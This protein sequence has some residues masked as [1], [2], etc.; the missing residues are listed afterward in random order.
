VLT[1][2]FGTWATK[3][4]ASM[5]R[6]DHRTARD[7]G[8]HE[9]RHAEHPRFCTALSGQWFLA[10]AR[11]RADLIIHVLGRL[12][13]SGLTL[14]TPAPRRQRQAKRAV[15][16]HSSP[17]GPSSQPAPPR[18]C[19][20]VPGRRFGNSSATWPLPCSAVLPNLTTESRSVLQLTK[21]LTESWAV[22]RPDAIRQ[23]P[24]TR[25]G[26]QRKT[27]TH[28]SH[29]VRLRRRAPS[30][31]V[32]VSFC[33]VKLLTVASSFRSR[34]EIGGGVCSALPFRQ[35]PVTQQAGPC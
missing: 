31:S 24:G 27:R 7:W 1:S 26:V 29:P 11:P 30:P 15:G 14:T 10:P 20:L 8:T 17:L 18:P 34:L 5:R 33:W 3:T 6:C 16:S 13:W 35:I 21:P 32:P 4:A 19:C 22:A 9:R 28:F 23:R 2:S 12:L 25:P